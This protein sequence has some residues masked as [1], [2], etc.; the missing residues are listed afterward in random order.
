MAT[1]NLPVEY[2]VRDTSKEL[3]NLSLLANVSRSLWED[4]ND[5]II[6]R[7]EKRQIND[8]EWSFQH[9]T[10]VSSYFRRH[11]G[12]KDQERHNRV[13]RNFTIRQGTFVKY[14]AT[15]YNPYND[16]LYHEDNNRVIERYFDI[17]IILSFQPE[18][19]IYNRFGIQHLDEFE[20][21]VHMS[22][23]ME[24]QYASLK[25]NCVEPACNPSDHN[26]IWS[27]RGYEDFRYYG[28]SAEQ[29]F[30][31]P[32]DMLKL[33][34]FNTLYEVESIKN[35]APEY[36]HRE[37]HYWWKLFLKDAM[38]TGRTVDPEVLND[39]EQEGFIN[40]LIGKQTGNGLQDD[41]GNTTKWPFDASCEVETLKKDVLFRPPEVDESVENISC[42]NNFYPCYDKF[43]KW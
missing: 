33:E 21:H 30:P 19:E 40:D 42:D 29:I 13:T 6:E 41:L 22:L 4:R 39:P 32:G 3:P 16:G 23:F 38:D 24:L 18:N 15:S 8:P 9:N 34:A 26:P 35:A 25:R 12:F 17:P 1:I 5:G 31:K 11:N 28:Y 2:N 27:Q 10:G 37:R 43:G 20:V 36:R 14:Y 7:S